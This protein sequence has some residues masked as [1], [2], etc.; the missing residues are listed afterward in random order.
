VGEP[1]TELTTPEGYAAK[2]TPLPKGGTAEALA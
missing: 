2:R 1:A